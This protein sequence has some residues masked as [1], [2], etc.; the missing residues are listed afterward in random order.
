M[1][2]HWMSEILGPSRMDGQMG[3]VVGNFVNA[4]GA[5]IDNLS[6]FADKGKQ[7]FRHRQAKRKLARILASIS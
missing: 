1:R 4:I 5:K 6:D 3:L 2:S 7:R